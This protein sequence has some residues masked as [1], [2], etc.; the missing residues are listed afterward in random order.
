LYNE[1][2]NH[3][4]NEGTPILIGGNVKAYTLLGVRNGEYLI[5]DP[6]Y[7]G[8]E[9]IKRV[10]SKGYCSWKKEDLFKDDSFYNFC[11]PLAHS[12]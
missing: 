5:L 1:I 8:E 6:H 3:F 4:D 10:I 2:A 9:S 11:L 12:K 7:I